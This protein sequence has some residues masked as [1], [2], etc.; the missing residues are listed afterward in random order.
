MPSPADNLEKLEADR[1]AQALLTL[2]EP[3]WPTDSEHQIRVIKNGLKVELVVLRAVLIAACER[4]IDELRVKDPQTVALA[5]NRFIS[6]TYSAKAVVR[7]VPP[8]PGADQ[9][10][11]ATVLR[12]ESCLLASPGVSD[13]QLAAALP[14]ML[15]ETSRAQHEVENDAARVA[16]LS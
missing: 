3:A 2:G 1:V 5:A 11:P 10:S 15:E 14:K 16:D 7:R 12:T 13:A 6:G 4:P 8:A 9:S